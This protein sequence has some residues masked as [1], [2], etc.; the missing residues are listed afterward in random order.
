[1]AKFEIKMIFKKSADM[2]S[3]HDEINN[4]CNKTGN[5][6]LHEE[7]NIITY[8]SDS[9]NTFAPAFV[10]LIYSDILKTNLLDALWKDP[11]DDEH[12]CKKNI[13]EPLN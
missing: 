12:S 4:I 9:I 10:H 3:L 13:L 8:G 1:M 5:T 7:G 2:A 11:Y 6:I